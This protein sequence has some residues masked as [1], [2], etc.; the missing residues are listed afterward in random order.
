MVKLA[1]AWAALLSLGGCLVVP[2]PRPSS[3]QG[4]RPRLS[5]D[6]LQAIQPGQARRRDVLLLLGEPDEV[7]RVGC[8]TV[9]AY[10]VG[11]SASQV[12]W[13]VCRVE[14]TEHHGRR[15]YLFVHSDFDGLVRRHGFLAH[16]VS[17]GHLGSSPLNGV[18]V[19]AL[20]TPAKSVGE[21][22]GEWLKETSP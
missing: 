8:E 22:A 13:S 20:G 11:A 2:L 6:R 16:A 1:G 14:G 12:R 7:V 17:F 10:V 9:D 21:L 5:P 3:D 15:D 18:D 19:W 4:A